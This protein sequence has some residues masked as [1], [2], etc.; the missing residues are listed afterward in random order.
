MYGHRT[1]I[2]R[3]QGVQMVSKGQVTYWFL[4]AMLRNSAREWG[5]GGIANNVLKMRKV[6]EKWNISRNSNR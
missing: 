1:Q 6:I 5:V 4:Y 2:E 3:A